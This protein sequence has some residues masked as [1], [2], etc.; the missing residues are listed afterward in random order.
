VSARTLADLPTPALL[1]DVDRLEANIAR[2]A[3]SMAGAG[4]ALR[5]HVKTSKCWEVAK[6]QLAAGAIGFTCS[7]AAEVAWLQGHGVGDLLWAH[8]PV[9]PR[10]VEFAVGTAAGGGLTV[11]LDSVDA[12]RPLAEAAAAAGVTV[13][14]VLEVNTGQA[15]LGVD[16]EQA[17][18]TA[19]QICAL[20]GLRL[21]GILTHEGHI[22]AA[23]DRPGLERAGRAA[24]TLL[25]RV[26][27]DLRGAGHEV[28]L[29]S[30]GSTPGATSTPFAPGITEAR[31]GT[32][33]YYDANQ[34]RN[35]S[36]TLA[37]CALTVLARVAS[38]QR[39]GRA[40]TDGGTKAMSSDS[41]GP[42]G[43]VGLVCD[44]SVRSLPDIT[45]ADANEE[46]GFLVGDGASALRVGD[47]VRL[48]PNHACGTTNMWGHAYAV[49]GDTVLDRWEISARH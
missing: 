42:A 1:I 16:P 10:K 31:M 22:T 2:M 38:V 24:G 27:D 12:A 37:D 28:E 32:Y 21:R 19:A 48:V 47:L 33:V 45:F 14:F 13:P 29:V 36:S 43:S 26:A 20:P 6:R 18:P 30:V 34:T 49:R 46:H 17:V 4:I 11:S 35:G 8:I 40:I 41:V 7:T 25:A 23:P 39:S 9:G 5:P 44:P 3:G 15:R